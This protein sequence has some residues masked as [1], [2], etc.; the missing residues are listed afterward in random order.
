MS[1]IRNSE[2]G[3]AK[4]TGACWGRLKLARATRGVLLVGKRLRSVSISLRKSP[5]GP[6]DG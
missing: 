2:E 6:V 4:R 1:G 3:E 5:K